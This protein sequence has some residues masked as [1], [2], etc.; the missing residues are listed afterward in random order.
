[1]RGEKR[2]EREDIQHTS[3]NVSRPLR[4]SKELDCLRLG[5]L[6]VEGT[7]AASIHSFHMTDK[8]TG[9]ELQVG[10]VP[11]YRMAFVLTSFSSTSEKITSFEAHPD[12]IRAIAVHPTSP[13]VLTASDDMLIK[14][15]SKNLAMS[16]ILTFE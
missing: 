9:Y 14:L 11:I 12:Y 2:F 3:D 8:P 16:T 5:R 15:V 4:R 13:F 1:V 7:R 6:P 10:Q